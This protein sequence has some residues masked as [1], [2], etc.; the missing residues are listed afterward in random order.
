M[1][2][3]DGRVSALALVGSLLFCFGLLVFSPENVTP[4]VQQFCGLT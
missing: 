4:I 3:V 1:S 2:L